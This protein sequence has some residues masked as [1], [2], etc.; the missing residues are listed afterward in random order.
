MK[1]L[2]NAPELMTVICNIQMMESKLNY[3]KTPF[4]I[5]EHMTD[6]QLHERQSQLIPFYN[7]KMMNN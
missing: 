5:L 7:S 1:R 2:A 3:K 6:E 4:V